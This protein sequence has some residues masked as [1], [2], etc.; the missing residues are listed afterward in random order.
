MEIYTKLSPGLKQ[1]KLK[2]KRKQ[3]EEKQK[4]KTLIQLPE[5][6]DTSSTSKLLKLSLLMLSVRHHL[7]VAHN[8]GRVEEK[9]S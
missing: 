4:K 7:R 5:Q 9:E 2:M 6:A 8:T 1:K 3:L